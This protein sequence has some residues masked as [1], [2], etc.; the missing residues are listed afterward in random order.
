MNTFDGPVWIY[1]DGTDQFTEFKGSIIG[2]PARIF[3]GFPNRSLISNQQP[4]IGLYGQWNGTLVAPQST[5]TGDMVTGAT[6]DGTFFVNNFVLH[7]GRF[8]R[9]APFNFPWVPTCV[10]GSFTDCS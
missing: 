7:Q 2:D 5:V 8:V 6:L 10:P 1:V 3:I 9:R 4:H